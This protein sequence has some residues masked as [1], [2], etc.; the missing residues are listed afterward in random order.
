MTKRSIQEVNFPFNQDR[1]NKVATHKKHMPVIK[2]VCGF[3]ILVLPDMKAMNT[4]INKHVAEHKKAGDS[5]ER[6]TELLAEQVMI[7]ASKMNLPSIN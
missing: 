3:E 5:P 6:L 2:C 1:H 4:A 7:L